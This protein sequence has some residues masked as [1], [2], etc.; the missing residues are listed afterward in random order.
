MRASRNAIYMKWVVRLALVILAGGTAACGDGT[1]TTS[2]GSGDSDVI[3]ADRD[4]STTSTPSRAADPSVVAPGPTQT[5]P[6]TSSSAASG[7]SDAPITDVTVLSAPNNSQTLTNRRVNLSKVTV[8]SVVSDQ[9][10]WI[11]NGTPQIF[12]VLNP[13]LDSGSA[14]ETIQ[15]R[16]GQV[17]DLA[18]TLR[19]MPNQTQA[20]LQWKL[21][22]TEAQ[23]LKSQ[24]LYLQADKVSFQQG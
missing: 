18:G 3:V 20:Q 13:A 2:N 11:G 19:P 10:F 23:A 1:R 21:N 5:D 22:E 8:Q 12:V 6:D 17:L 7:N 9:G 15:I 16:E 4:S 24:L 14:E